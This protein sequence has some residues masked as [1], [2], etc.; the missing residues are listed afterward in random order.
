MAYSVVFTPAAERSLEHLDRTISR[1]IKPKVLAL[2]DNP[3]PSGCVKLQGHSGLF[4]IRVG[5][6]RVV[7]H[8]DDARQLVEVTI[9]ANRREV[10]RDL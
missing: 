8:I 7:Y 1:R 6:Y 5:D 9:V 3:R 2:A 4:R 10:Y